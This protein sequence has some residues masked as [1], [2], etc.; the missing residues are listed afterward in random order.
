MA[1]ENVRLN[2]SLNFNER[3]PR[4]LLISPTQFRVTQSRFRSPVA[5]GYLMRPSSFAK[6]VGHDLQRRIQP[7]TFAACEYITRIISIKLYG[8]SRMGYYSPR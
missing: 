6:I 1:V 7:L 3:R 5:T 2:T 8:I 4:R